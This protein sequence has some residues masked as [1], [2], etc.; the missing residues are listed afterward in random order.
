MLDVHPPHS[1]THTWRDFLLHIATIVCGLLIA[2]GLEQS[3]EALHN[4]HAR[5]QLLEDVHSEFESNHHKNQLTLQSLAAL[6]IYLVALN[7]V[8]TLKQSGKPA[9]LDPSLDE[10]RQLQLY[11]SSMAAWQSAK[12][13]GRAAL[14]SSA[15]IRLYDRFDAQLDYR[16][17]EITAFGES[18]YAMQAFEERFRDT[19]VT[20]WWG[21]GSSTPDLAAMSQP[22]LAQYQALV[23]TTISNVDRV[24]SRTQVIEALNDA[25][26][27][28]AKTEDDLVKASYGPFR[29]SK[30]SQDS[31]PST[32]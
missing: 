18:V 23:A 8:L 22:Q 31:L 1:P 28:G 6:R 12:E 4:R 20:M 27:H 9:T 30:A 15:Q 26:F 7:R 11:G 3:V 2:I 24:A 25:L 14:L 21:A 32:K 10:R 17:D 5:H 19:S 29:V 16:H 13:S